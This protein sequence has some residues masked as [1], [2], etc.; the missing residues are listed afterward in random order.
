MIARVH[1]LR[2]LSQQAHAWAIRHQV[3]I[4]RIWLALAILYGVLRVFLADRY[5]SKYGLSTPIFA[6]IEMGATVLYAVALA[7]LVRALM[8]GHRGERAMWALLTLIGF[9][10]PDAYILT[11]VPKVPRSFV[12]VI[13]AIIVI[14]TTTGVIALRK[15]VRAIREPRVVSVVTIPATLDEVSHE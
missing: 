15:R 2:R 5:L 11:V 10:A 4:E 3:N 13:L 8:L 9:A 12:V 6:V 14:T 1:P 7:R